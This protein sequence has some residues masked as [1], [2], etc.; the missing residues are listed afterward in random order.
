MAL[1]LSRR[2]GEKLQ[3]GNIRIEFLEVAGKKVR[4][5]IDAPKEVKI[6]RCWFDFDDPPVDQEPKAT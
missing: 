4:L 1:V 3:I 6:L 2:E 5:A